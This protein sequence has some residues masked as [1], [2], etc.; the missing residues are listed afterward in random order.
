VGLSS[1]VSG[2]S[3]SVSGWTGA[4]IDVTVA[5]DPAETYDLDE[6]L[7]VDQVDHV[8]VAESIITWC[9]GEDRAWFGV[10]TFSWSPIDDYAPQLGIRLTCTAACTY[11]PNATMQGL[12]NWGAAGA[13]AIIES[14]SGID[15]T[16]DSIFAVNQWAQHLDGKGMIA[17][18]GSTPID[19]S[20]FANF[21]PDISSI[22]TEVQH[23]AMVVATKDSSV[24]RTASVYHVAAETWRLVSFQRVTYSRGRQLYRVTLE[25]A[26][27]VGEAGGILFEDGAGLLLEAGDAHR[28]E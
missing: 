5:P 25:T 15:G 13:G 8:Q 10:Q 11:A 18:D 24:V 28:L 20:T 16:V 2:I 3:V 1:P 4:D 14:S 6:Q 17:R 26:G 22:M 9:N 21:W 12:M 7:N 27:D 19:H 23:H